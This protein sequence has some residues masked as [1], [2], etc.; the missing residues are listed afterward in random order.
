MALLPV[1]W[2]I[3]ILKP[4]YWTRIA[5]PIGRDCNWP[6]VA[7]YRYPYMAHNKYW[8]RAFAILPWASTFTS[9]RLR[10]IIH[11]SILNCSFYSISVG[12]QNYR[13]LS[14]CN[15]SLTNSLGCPF[16]SLSIFTRV[17]SLTYFVRSN[18]NTNF[19]HT[20]PY[21]RKRTKNN[22]AKVGKWRFVSSSNPYT[23]FVNN[24][25]QSIA[26]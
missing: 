20:S 19:T 23:L 8:W 24:S 22:V 4:I 17:E 16:L 2:C 12:N 7:P 15:I 18:S 21:N 25:K 11:L 9:A 14:I 26:M 1:T 13:P 6:H 10:I 5:S 3:W